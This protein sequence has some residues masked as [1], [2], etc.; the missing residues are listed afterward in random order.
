[1]KTS[2]KTLCAIALVA[3]LGGC[4]SLGGTSA[5]TTA[6]ADKELTGS[7]AEGLRLARM[8]RDNGRMEGAA[9]IYARLDQRGELKGALLLEYATVAATVSSPRQALALFGR[10]RQEMGGDPMALPPATGVA[11]CNGLGRAR[12]ALGQTDAALGDFD[13]ALKLDAVNTVALNGKAV[14]LD[15]QGEHEQAQ[16]LWRQ[17][18]E[19]DPA[20]FTLLNNL[21]LSYLSQ[22][23]TDETIRLLRQLDMP[24]NMPTLTLNLALAYLLENQPEQADQ[25]LRQLVSERQ[26]EQL[27]AQLMRYSTRIREGEPVAAELLVA[28]RQMLALQ[29]QDE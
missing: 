11:L 21:A 4:A 20:D 27:Q 8:L 9:G 3:A 2:L 6:A 29:D 15:A 28:S 1:M 25:A 13:C 26:A 18:Q 5:S 19:I 24:R 14:I 16:V 7:L 23:K 10:A 22:G 12:L 17:A